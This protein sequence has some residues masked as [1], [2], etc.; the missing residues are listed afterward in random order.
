MKLSQEDGHHQPGVMASIILFHQ[1][2]DEADGLQEGCQSLAMVLEGSLPQR[3]D[4]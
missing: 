2:D 4:D 3:A 1:R